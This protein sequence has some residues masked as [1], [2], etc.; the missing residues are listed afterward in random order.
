MI[1]APVAIIR[2]WWSDPAYRAS[3]TV[4]GI[5]SVP[6]VVLVVVGQILGR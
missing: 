2:D 3:V 4:A 1:R 6:L 5:I